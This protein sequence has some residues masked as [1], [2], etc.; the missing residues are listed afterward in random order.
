MPKRGPGKRGAKEAAEPR[1][2]RPA[3]AGDRA[4]DD[5]ARDGRQEVEVA[6]VELVASLAR[7]D[8]EAAL[9]YEAAAD[10]CAEEDLARHLRV[11]A[12][13]HRVHVDALN[14]ALEAGG[15][16]AA[17][18]LAAPAGPVFAGLVRITGP[19]GDEVIVVTLLGNEQLTNLSYDAALAY[20]WDRDTEAMLRRFQ[21][22]EERHIAWLA[23]EHDALGGHAEQPDVPSP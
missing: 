6:A 5:G 2:G 4:V 15:E 12:K 7:L 18:P 14:E 20:E 21:E 8:L 17:A 9:A 10:L 19:L 13:D 22:D 3:V 23:S 16:P 1:R 11:F